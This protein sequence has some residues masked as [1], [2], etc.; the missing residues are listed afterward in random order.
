ME[1][2]HK[3]LTKVTNSTDKSF[4][5]VAKQSP[6]QKTPKYLQQ[7]SIQKSKNSTSNHF[8]NL[9]ISLKIL[10]SNFLFKWENKNKISQ[11]K[12]VQNIRIFGLH[13]SQKTPGP[14]KSSPNS[15][16]SP[17]LVTLV[18]TYSEIRLSISYGITEDQY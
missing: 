12:I 7:S 2:H 4:E 18:L 13:F 14:S 1:P 11:V 10:L 17:N 9:K 6:N 15:K 3:I 5:K 8:W 16:F